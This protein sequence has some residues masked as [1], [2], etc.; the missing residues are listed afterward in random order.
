MIEI[1]L[2][3]FDFMNKIFL[4][5]QSEDLLSLFDVW[6]VVKLKFDV[7]MDNYLFIISIFRSENQWWKSIAKK[8]LISKK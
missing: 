3:Y 5:K 7:F 6:L 2:I 8:P 1:R 4:M